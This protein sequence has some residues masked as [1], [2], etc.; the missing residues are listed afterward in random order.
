MK[1]LLVNSI[2]D[3]MLQKRM[4]NL[5]SFSAIEHRME[6]V[7]TKDGSLWINDS[8]STDMGATAFTLE[9]LDGQIVWIVGCDESNRNLELVKDLVEQKVQKIICNP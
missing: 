1:K 3:K 5:S 2:K 7:Q 4:E 6:L 9:Q 8:K